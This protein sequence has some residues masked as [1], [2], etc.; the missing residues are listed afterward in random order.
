MSSTNNKDYAGVGKPKVTGAVFRAASGT[1]APTSATASLTSD[2]KAMGY[3]SDDGVTNTNSPETSEIKAWGGD[4]II[5]TQTSK[6]DTFKLKM[7]EIL[8]TEVQKAVYGSDNVSVS[9]NKSTITANSKEGDEGVWVIDMI[10]GLYI[11]RIVIPD[12]KITEIGDIVYK[13]DEAIGYETTITALP[14]SDGNTHYE[15]TEP[16]TG[17]TGA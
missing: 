15:Y 8:N 16:I 1:T 5:V 13:D 9:G 6:P 2:Y 7:V 3:V 11:K 12:G 10:I 4:T 17:A 14:D